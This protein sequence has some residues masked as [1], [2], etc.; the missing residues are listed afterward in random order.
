[1]MCTRTAERVRDRAD[2]LDV[3]GDED[4]PSGRTLAAECPPRVSDRITWRPWRIRA[5]STEA[6]E[7]ALP[8]RHGTVDAQRAGAHRPDR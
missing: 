7:E 2:V 1:M 5:P 3:G 8:P 4:D 6:G